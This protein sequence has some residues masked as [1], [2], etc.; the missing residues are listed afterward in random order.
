MNWF[1]SLGRGE[2]VLLLVSFLIYFTF[3]LSKIIT[4]PIFVD[5]AQTYNWF[6]QKGFFA[7]LSSY[8]STNNHV[9]FS[10]ITNFFHYLPVDAKISLRLPNLL[11]G[12]VF[13][14]TSFS[15][16]KKFFSTQV[17]LIA[18]NVIVFSYVFL[19]YT[20]MARGYMLYIVS[21]ALCFFC[22]VELIKGNLNRKYWNL[23]I[24]F[25]V[26]G[27]YSIP[28]FVYPLATFSIFLLFIFRKNV[29]QIKRLIVS[30]III[31]L[32]TVL[33]YFPI[34]YFNDYHKVF[35]DNT[36]LLSL[37]VNDIGIFL[38]SNFSGFYNILLGIHSPLL[39]LLYFLAIIFVF[40]KGKDTDDRRVIPLI[41][42]LFVLPF[43]FLMIQR[44]IP[45][46]RMWSYLIFPF[47]FGLALVIQKIK[48]L[49]TVK[50]LVY[51]VIPV[52]V[53]LQIIIFNKSHK[54]GFLDRDIESEALS[55]QLLTYE[56]KTFYFYT[57]TTIEECILR[58]N[59][60]SN[61][62]PFKCGRSYYF[63]EDSINYIPR[64]YSYDCLVIDKNLKQPSNLFDTSN[65]SLVYSNNQYNIFGK[66]K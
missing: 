59:F 26:I 16:F 10:V 33:L 29:E 32:V 43:V 28:T 48:I 4:F 13:F 5:E 65:Y 53:F 31:C 6:T 17:A 11:L 7:S 44:I 46:V 15:I 23:F 24:V 55:K 27:L 36:H 35:T 47:G 41:I 49:S 60:L 30:G 3:C 18:N 54:Q 19:H 62:K 56:F 38:S 63:A 22:I 25:S 39:F 61:N 40:V 52:S 37:S 50:W 2:R 21:C 58:F 8:P 12:S 51:L 14:V 42:L 20:I 1:S 57:E 45:V 66:E 34:F 9:L 64:Q